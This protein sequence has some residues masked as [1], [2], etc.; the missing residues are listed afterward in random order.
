MY[1]VFVTDY[2]GRNGLPTITSEWCPAN[3][4]DKVFRI[5]MWEEAVHGAQDMKPGEFW[6]FGNMRMK[7]DS[8]GFFEGSFSEIW[9]A[10]KLDPEEAEH[11]PYLLALIQ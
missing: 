11:N 4:T 10:H 1:T 3:L 6:S 2:T 9:K 7:I 8:K 5:E